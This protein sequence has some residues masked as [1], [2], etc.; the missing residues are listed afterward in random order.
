[1]SESNG[2]GVVLRWAHLALILSV[3]LVTV[4]AT[5]GILKFEVEDHARRLA[6][7]ERKQEANF[8]LR[9]EYDNRH[10]DL[11]RQI[12]EMKLQLRDVNAILAQHSNDLTNVA[13][14]VGVTAHPVPPR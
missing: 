11:I 6:D 10:Q 5:F 13:A 1:M 3:Q 4:G 14:K 12:E 9:S 7:V 2:S 8:I